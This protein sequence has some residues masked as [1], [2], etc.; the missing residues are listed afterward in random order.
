M[1]SSA[2]SEY[3][4]DAGSSDSRDDGSSG[5]SGRDEDEESEDEGS[6]GYKKGAL[7]TGR[8]A[9]LALTLQMRTRR[10]PPRHSRRHV[11]GRPLLR[12][13]Q[14]GLGPLLYRLACAR[15]E[16]RQ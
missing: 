6:D 14:A 7:A 12:A 8:T 3:S 13:A 16:H 1:P 10:L 15:R 5:S 2:T 4:T 9:G 11:Q